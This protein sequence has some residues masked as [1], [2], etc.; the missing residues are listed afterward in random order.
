MAACTQKQAPPKDILPQDKMVDLL[1]DIR[2]LEGAYSI[3]Y[4][5]I[6]TSALKID[7]YF[8]KLFSDGGVSREQFLNS[9]KYYAMQDT[10]ML[11]M[12]NE[13]M[14]KLSEFQAQEEAKKN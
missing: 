7:A 5:K 13:V 9:Y 1:T 8:Q 4:Q 10:K 3:K 14:E 12:E 6:D 2:L 11:E